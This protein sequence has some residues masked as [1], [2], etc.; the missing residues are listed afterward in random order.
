[1]LKSLPFVIHLPF[2]QKCNFMCKPAKKWCIGKFWIYWYQ[3]HLKLVA[4]QA[5]NI[6]FSRF[7]FEKLPFSDVKQNYCR[8]KIGV[9]WEKSMK[10]CKNLINVEEYH[11]YSSIMSKR[12]RNNKFL[13]IICHFSYLFSLSVFNNLKTTRLWN[14]SIFLN[15]TLKNEIVL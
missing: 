6:N 1:M 9:K 11:K 4:K 15:E 14:F 13:A 5:K 3:E 7:F 2:S 10:S 12:D 8:L